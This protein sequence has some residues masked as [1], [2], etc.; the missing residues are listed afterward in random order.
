MSD[1]RAKN[2]RNSSLALWV[3]Q[4]MHHRSTGKSARAPRRGKKNHILALRDHKSYTGC[5]KLFRVEERAPH[6]LHNP[7][8]MHKSK[9]T[10]TATP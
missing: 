3:Q 7:A 5:W 1:G 10:H 2:V 9:D 8:D 6:R 4:L